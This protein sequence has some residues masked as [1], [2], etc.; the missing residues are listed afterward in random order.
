[1]YD[2]EQRSRR[3]KEKISLHASPPTPRILIDRIPRSRE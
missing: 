1:M 3:W 2:V